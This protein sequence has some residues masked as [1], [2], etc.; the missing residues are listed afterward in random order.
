MQKID[1]MKSYWFRRR[2]YGYGWRP[3]TWQGWLATLLTL[4]S[5]LLS[6]AFV[7]LFPTQSVS[8]YSII[9]ISISVIMLIMLCNASGPSPKW[10][11]GDGSNNNS[12]KK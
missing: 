7:S 6:G 12:K 2:R 9:Q 10:Q 3:I 8:W 4:I 1:V 11:W 5:I